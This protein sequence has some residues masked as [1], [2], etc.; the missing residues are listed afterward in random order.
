MTIFEAPPY[1]RV[2]SPRVAPQPSHRRRTVPIC[3]FCYHKV[4]TV[5]LGKVLGGISRINGWNFRVLV[6][7][8]TELPADADVILFAHSL[9]DLGTIDKPFLGVHFIRDP[10][11]IVVSGYLFHLRT[12]ERWCVNTDLDPSPPIRF[13]RVPRSQQHRSESWK[14]AYLRSL[15]GRSYQEN[16]RALPQAEGLLFEMNHYAGWTIDSM[17]AWDYDR[18]DVLEVRFEDLMSEFDAGF[19][20]I[21]SWL[22]LSAEQRDAALELAARHDLGRKSREEIQQIE[23]VSPGETSKWRA[24]FEP[25]HKNAFRARFGEVLVDLGYETSDDW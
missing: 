7:W 13:P 1:H 5:L 23:H 25:Q 9:I 22:G 10:R 18:E 15:G 6:G 20:F 3:V 8:Q 19:R 17:R 11:D 12:R 4:G 21:F 14:A 2:G 16:L 24:Y